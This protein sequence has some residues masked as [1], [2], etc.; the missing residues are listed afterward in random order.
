M[1]FLKNLLPYVK[2]GLAM[3]TNFLPPL[4]GTAVN[5]AVQQ[6]NDEAARQGVTTE[7]LISH[8]ETRFPEVGKKIDDFQARLE[9]D[10]AAGHK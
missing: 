1:E 4:L 9:R 7:Q 6:F 5:E 2:I 10:A 8:L 3:G